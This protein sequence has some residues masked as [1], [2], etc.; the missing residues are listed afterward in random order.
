MLRRVRIFFAALAGTA[1][2][3]GGEFGCG[4]PG[5]PRAIGLHRVCRVNARLRIL[6][7]L[8]DDKRHCDAGVSE[9]RQQLQRSESVSGRGATVTIKIYITAA[10]VIGGA[11]IRDYYDI[12]GQYWGL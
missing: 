8:A 3:D 1:S 12:D 4:P 7:R 10:V 5:L 6:D 9:P 11:K 2:S